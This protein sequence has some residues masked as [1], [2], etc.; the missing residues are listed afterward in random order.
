MASFDVDINDYKEAFEDKNDSQW[1][2]PS[3][4]KMVLGFSALA[5]VCFTLG[6]AL[7]LP[8]TQNQLAS[9]I[10]KIDLCSD[11][12]DQKCGNDHGR[13]QIGGE[14]QKRYCSN[15]GWCTNDVIADNKTDY[16]NFHSGGNCQVV[17][18]APGRRIDLATP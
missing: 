15:Q 4:G 16:P 14:G 5:F 17:Q 13:C 7:N 10:Q 8:V 18:G 12:K 1:T 3:V 11:S 2:L 9:H 6:Y